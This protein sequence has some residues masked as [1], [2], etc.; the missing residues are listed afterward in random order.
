MEGGQ[1]SVRVL[2]E[3]IFE[4]EALEVL[5]VPRSDSMFKVRNPESH[6]NGLCTEQYQ[7]ARKTKY[8][9]MFS[10]ASPMRCVC[11]RCN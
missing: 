5:L 6:D 2:Y 7:L 4:V 3:M 8:F 10:R 11:T 9:H 1:I